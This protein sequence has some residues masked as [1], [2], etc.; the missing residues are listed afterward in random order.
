MSLLAST[1]Y[2]DIKTSIEKVEATLPDDLRVEVIYF[3]HGLP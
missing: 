2:K 3:A 1:L